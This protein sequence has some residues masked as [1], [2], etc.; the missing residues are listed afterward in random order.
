MRRFLLQNEGAGGGGGGCPRHGPNVRGSGSAR[1]ECGQPRCGAWGDDVRAR[2]RRSCGRSGEALRRQGK[3]RDGDAHGFSR[4]L[5]RGAPVPF[6]KSGSLAKRRQNVLERTK[7]ASPSPRHI[8]AFVERDGYSCCHLAAA[9]TSA[10]VSVLEPHFLQ[11]FTFTNT[12][13]LRR[14]CRTFRRCRCAPS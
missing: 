11:L 13:S 1:R 8:S 6:H 5:S 9:R 12:R 3:S 7:K 14:K 10:A 2:T 4:T